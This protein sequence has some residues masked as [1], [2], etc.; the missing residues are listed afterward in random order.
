MKLIYFRLRFFFLFCLK[1]KKKNSF[2]SRKCQI[3]NNTQNWPCHGQK[4]EQSSFYHRKPMV[5]VLQDL[6]RLT[7]TPFLSF[8]FFFFFVRCDWCPETVVLV[9]KLV[10]HRGVSGKVLTGTKITRDGEGLGDND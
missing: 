6:N 3:K 4:K 9:V 7:C 10:L 8:F 5:C 2:K 1:K